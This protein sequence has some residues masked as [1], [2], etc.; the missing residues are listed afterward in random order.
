MKKILLFAILLT[1]QVL[2]LKSQTC[3]GLHYR[4]FIYQ[5]S[6][7]SNIVYGSNQ[8]M[9]N[10]TI[11]LKLDMHLPQADTS[12]NRPVII[13]AHGGNF[14]G[15]SKTGTDVLQFC[16]DF[17]K[18]GYVVASI[19]YRVGMTNFPFPGP[20]STDA[21]EAVMRA[22]QD[23][24]A[25]VRFLRKDFENGNQYRIDTSKIYFLGVSAGGFIGL[26]MAYLDRNSE[27]PSWA[28][29]TNQYGL[30]GGLEGL[31]GNPGY[32]SKIAGVI[33][34]C[35]AIGDTAYIEPGDEPAMLF[36]G[37]QDNTVPYGS[38]EI[39]LLGQYPLLQVDGSYSIDAKLTQVGVEH[40]FFT[41]WGQDHTPHVTGASSNPAAYYDT[42]LVISRNWLVHYVCGD[43][44]D[45]SYTTNVAVNNLAALAPLIGVYPNPTHSSFTINTERLV[46]TDFVYEM[47][48]CTGQLVRSENLS[49]DGVTHVNTEDLPSGIYMVNIR[50]GESFYSTKVVV[51]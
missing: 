43:P 16:H 19:D 47:Y 18:M 7:V 10:A 1:T 5:D 27:F 49:A 6:T 51:E 39:I 9:S 20:D 31:S 25:A 48:S 24:K 22:V 50:N 29:T 23:G 40:C 35:G 41:Y 2:N 33:N 11:S 26:H 44:L 42:T 4:D 46:G 32:S 21:T 15:G 38:A 37:D 3:N 14:L 36:H 12:T 13:I 45:C 28:D 34:I 17:A 8:S 30:H